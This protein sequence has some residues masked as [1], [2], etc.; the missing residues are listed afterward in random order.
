M[1]RTQKAILCSIVIVLLTLVML[2]YV[3]FQF[4]VLEQ[5]PESF[6]GRFLPPII[7]VV[8]GFLLLVWVLRH[9]PRQEEVKTDESDTLIANKAAMV[10]LVAA[11]VV[12]PAVGVIPRIILGDDGCIPAWSLPLINVG[13]LVIVMMAYLMAVLVQYISERNKRSK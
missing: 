11:W 13:A 1:N 9:R 5:T 2:A 7:L 8:A 4:F 6:A 10:A 12:F 3:L